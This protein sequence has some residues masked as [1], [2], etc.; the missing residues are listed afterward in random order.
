MIGYQ[1]AA[2]ASKIDERA[3]HPVTVWQMLTWLGSQLVALRMGLQL[4]AQQGPSSTCHRF[5]GAVAASKFRSPQR[6]QELR[7]ARRLLHLI[8]RWDS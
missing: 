1:T 7:H 3:L 8:D 4:I 6:E 2:A 5:M